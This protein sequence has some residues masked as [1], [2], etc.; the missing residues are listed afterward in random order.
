MGGAWGKGPQTLLPNIQNSLLSFG[1][2]ATE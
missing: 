1:D 2:N